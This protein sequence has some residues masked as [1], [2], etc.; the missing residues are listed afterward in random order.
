MS[1]HHFVREGQEPALVIVD[2]LGL[3]LTEPLLEWVPQVVVLND[4]VDDVKNWG[5]KID[6][7]IR[8]SYSEEHLSEL[9]SHQFPFELVTDKY[10][11]ALVTA[12]RFLENAGQ[13]AVN[14]VMHL[15]D[16]RF[17]LLEKFAHLS[18]N[19]IT[20][21]ERWL[22]CS[23][24][25]EKWTPAGSSLSLRLTQDGQQVALEGLT[26]QNQGVTSLTD[27][28]VRISSPQLFW[29]GDSL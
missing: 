17:R 28:T 3:D 14:L 9:L 1:S 6:V 19:V 23:G 8:T 4:A 24:R 29:V 22:L 12:L 11:D 20:Q 5:I 15:S 10:G 7:V 16:D 27:G 25:F 13:V 2:A 21:H 18:I 26:R